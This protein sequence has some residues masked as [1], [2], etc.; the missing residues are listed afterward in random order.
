MVVLNIFQL[1][2]VTIYAEKTSDGDSKDDEQGDNITIL[3]YY[4]NTIFE[5][6]AVTIYAEKTS[7]GDSQDDEQGYEG[8]QALLHMV[9]AYP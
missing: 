7:D 3:K 9:A 5:L 1:T 8:D 4:N 6:T 2:A